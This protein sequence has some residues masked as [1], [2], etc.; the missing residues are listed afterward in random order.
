MSFAYTQGT[1]SHFD[2]LT[3]ESY[4]RFIQGGFVN[5]GDTAVPI[6]EAADVYILSL[7]SFQWFKANSPSGGPRAFLT[8]HSA[9]NNQMIL[10]GGYDYT[11]DLDLDHTYPDP[12]SQQIAVFDMTALLW[13]DKYESSADPYASPEIVKQFYNHS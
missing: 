3:S 12:W 7:P 11:Y 13:K 6:S 5:R 1:F 10:V 4:L 8:C 2:L 9:G